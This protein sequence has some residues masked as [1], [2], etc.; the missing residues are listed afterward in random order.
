MDDKMRQLERHLGF[1]N[2]GLR[3]IPLGEKEDLFR[4]LTQFT[5]NELKLYLGFKI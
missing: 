5:A 4:Y 2:K 1:D 3:R